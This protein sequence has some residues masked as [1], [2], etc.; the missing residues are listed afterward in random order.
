MLDVGVAE[1][2]LDRADVH[3]IAQEPT[4]ALVTEVVPVQVDLTESLMIEANTG[5]NSLEHIIRM[6]LLPRTPKRRDTRSRKYARRTV[7]S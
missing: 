5:S 3:S 7:S 6:N 2:Q 1:H 4:G